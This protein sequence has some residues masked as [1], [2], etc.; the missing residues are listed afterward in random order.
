MEREAKK[1]EEY[2]SREQVSATEL[3]MDDGEIAQ[4]KEMDFMYGGET[5]QQELEE[6]EE[7]AEQKAL[8]P[9]MKR[10]ERNIT[11]Q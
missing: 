11:P 5:T 6:L 1:K 9:Y 3:G 4:M 2:A 10:K 7:E 8:D